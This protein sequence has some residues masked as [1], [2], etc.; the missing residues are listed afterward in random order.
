MKKQGLAISTMTSTIGSV[1]T[2]LLG[3]WAMIYISNKIG[4]EGMGLYH[5]TTTIY[6]MAYMIASAGIITSVSRLVAEE[7]SR[8][9]GYR[10]RK[11]MNI[12]FVLG[13]VVSTIISGVVFVYAESISMFVIKDARTVLGLRVLSLSIPFMTVSACFKG[14]FYAVKKVVKPASADVLEQIAKLLLITYFLQ[15]FAPR[16]IDYACGAIGLGITIGEMI[17][18]TY[19]FVLYLLDKERKMDKGVRVSEEGILFKILKVLLPISVT[20][21]LGSVFMLLENTL[22]PEGLRRSGLSAEAAMSMYGMIKGMVYPILFFPTALLSACS[23]ILTPEIAR[24]R[25]LKYQERIEITS[26][27]MIH[28]T[29]I[30]AMFVVGVF[31]NYGQ[32]LGLLIYDNAQVGKLLEILVL[33][34]PFMYMEIVVDGILKGLGEQNSCLRY[35]IID[36]IFRVALIYWLIPMEGVSAFIGIT[37]ISNVLTSVLNLRRLIKVT[38]IRVNVN[39]WISYP[40]L[41]GIAAGMVSKVFVLYMIPRTLDLFARVM[42]GIGVASCLYGVFLFWIESLTREDLSV[43][44]ISRR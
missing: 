39:K 22:I 15:K 12:F 17:S 24:A 21:Y 35:R 25:S 3:M 14:Y 6:S 28:F 9:W 1:M 18:F 2:R 30:L 19:M 43:M 10:A 42:I 27:R 13:I 33:M 40:A 16:G 5:L 23:T 31:S 4:P 37:L 41:S 11:T 8:G 26:G 38:E 20:A 44:S 36:S 29:M 7:L 34:T 32:E